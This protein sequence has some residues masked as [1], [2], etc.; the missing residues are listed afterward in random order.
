[1]GKHKRVRFYGEIIYEFGA[2][3]ENMTHIKGV[4]NLFEL[5]EISFTRFALKS[6]PRL[7]SPVKNPNVVFIGD[8][9]NRTSSRRGVFELQRS[10]GEVGHNIFLK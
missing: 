1:M 4:S 10:G 9:L 5:C 6:S 7:T 3:I 2:G 8:K